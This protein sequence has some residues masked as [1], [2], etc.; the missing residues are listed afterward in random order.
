MS[1]AQIWVSHESCSKKE[2]SL[3]FNSAEGDQICSQVFFS[4][5]LFLSDKNTGFPQ[6]R[7]VGAVLL[8]TMGLFLDFSYVL[9]SLRQFNLKFGQKFTKPRGMEPDW[10]LEKV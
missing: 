2:P 9:T 10:E 7:R 1:T 3:R 5:F 8:K 6:E 4:S